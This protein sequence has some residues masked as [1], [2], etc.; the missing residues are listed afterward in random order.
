MSKYEKQAENL[1]QTLG[2][3]WSPIAVTYS[4]DPDS[5]GSMDKQ[6]S[7]CKAL[8][9]VLLK[10]T[11][12]NL[13]RDNCLC[14]G[15][16]HYLGLEV[17]PPQILSMIWAKYHKAFESREMAEEQLNNYPKPPTQ[18][19]NF[20]ILSPVG[21]VTSDPDAV[22]IFC[23]PEQADR[24]TG[25]IAYSGYEPMLFY[26]VNNVCFYLAIPVVT[27]KTHLSFLSRHVR[28]IYHLKVPSSELFICAPYKDFEKAVQNIPHSGY[29]TAKTEVPKKAI[30]EDKEFHEI[31]AA[32]NK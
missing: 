23:N 20:V 11:I 22:I 24:V 19:A 27:G 31:L 30:K 2:L 16:K 12:V 6:P 8:E 32:L 29:G 5:R 17:V 18:K 3:E 21:K 28:E 14:P 10:N 9:K 15:G 13:S 7:V 1:R 25:L 4:D 26:P